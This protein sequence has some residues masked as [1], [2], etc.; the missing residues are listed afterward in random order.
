MAIEV[1]GEIGFAG[2]DHLHME[3]LVSLFW[4][5]SGGRRRPIRHREP[6]RS[7]Q[8]SGPGVNGVEGLEGFSVS[9]SPPSLNPL[10][11]FLRKAAGTS[12]P[13]SSP[14][15]EILTGLLTALFIF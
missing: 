13:Y 15:P 1:G 5:T 8:C 4:V 2:I 7:V 3:H 14:L 6:T 9:V 11:F 10:H 12:Y